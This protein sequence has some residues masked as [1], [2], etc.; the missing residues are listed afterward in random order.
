MPEGPR[1]AAGL[2]H[3]ATATGSNSATA[4]TTTAAAAAAERGVPGTSAASADRQMSDQPLHR[5]RHLPPLRHH[6]QVRG[7]AW[8]KRATGNPQISRIKSFLIY[9]ILHLRGLAPLGK[10]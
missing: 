7:F 10:S 9:L 1:S 2:T 5:G 3:S 8:M 6:Q 4:A